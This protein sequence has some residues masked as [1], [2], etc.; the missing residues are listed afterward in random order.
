MQVDVH[1]CPKGLF[2]WTVFHQSHGDLW[3]ILGTALR[4]LGL[5]IN[6]IG[7]HIRI[8]EIECFDRKRSLVHLT[9][10]PSS[11]LRFLG[12]DE[13]SYWRGWQTIN[14][15]FAYATGMRFWTKD[16]YV[17]ED[18]KANDKKRLVQREIYRRFLEEWV[19]RIPE[20]GSAETT[21]RES[22]KDE[23]LKVFGKQQDWEEV[24]RMWKAEKEE[25][26]KRAVAREERKR[27][28]M[29]EGIY[30]DSWIK[31]VEG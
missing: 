15:M 14:G 19:P 13:G 10:E 2:E 18:L 31:T 23:A 9:S 1:V 22:V 12:L 3:N 17:K 30:A 29:E 25:K 21:A 27:I 28:A 24:K 6:D 20:K 16:V 7:L 11:V 26:D 5:T 4:P 8:P